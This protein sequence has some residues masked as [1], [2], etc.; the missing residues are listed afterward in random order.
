LSRSIPPEPKDEQAEAELFVTSIL[1]RHKLLKVFAAEAGQQRFAIRSPTYVVGADVLQAERGRRPDADEHRVI[2]LEQLELEGSHYDV[3]LCINVLEHVSHPLSLFPVVRS[4]LKKG[5]IFV[6]VLPNVVSLK[7]LATRITPWRFHRWFY[8]RI[9]GAPPERHPV[10][11]IHS[12]S[13]RPS[14]LLRRARMGG[15]KVE[16]FRLYEGPTQRSVRS[17]IGIVGWRWRLLAAFT[18]LVTF[19]ALTA[20]ETGIIVVLSKI[21][22]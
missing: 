21:A 22:G 4:A 1:P 5:G 19:G 3:V 12:L 17:R 9:L 10:S 11:S 14:S 7:G 8:A 20:E 6:L 16:Y 2:D 18:R 15:W 13:L